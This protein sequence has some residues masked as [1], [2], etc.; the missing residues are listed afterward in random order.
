MSVDPTGDV[1]LDEDIVDIEKLQDVPLFRKSTEDRL[2]AGR[3]R[4][5]D[6][7]AQGFAACLDHVGQ[8]DVGEPI[9]PVTPAD[10]AMHARKP[11]LGDSVGSCLVTVD[12][13]PSPCGRR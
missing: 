4:V 2:A 8:A 1:G 13:G 10:I 12:E 7:V 11:D 3:L 9:V 5:F 6:L